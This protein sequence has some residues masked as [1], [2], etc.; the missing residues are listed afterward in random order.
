MA[1]SKWQELLV[2]GVYITAV[3]GS[4]A[5]KDPDVVGL[6]TTVV[7]ASEL[8]SAAVLRGLHKRRAYLVRDP[9]MDI[10]FSVK[11]QGNAVFQVG[12]RVQAKG[13]VTATVH[14]TGLDGATVVFVS[15]GGAVHQET[16]KAGCDIKYQVDKARFLRVEV[17]DAQNNM[18]GLTNP[19]FLQ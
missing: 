6:P 12:D 13:E 19:I 10:Q 7:R 14:T 1:V 5:H 18:L 8:S 2:A 3:G 15:E 11:A 16:I 17:R 4:D 9:G